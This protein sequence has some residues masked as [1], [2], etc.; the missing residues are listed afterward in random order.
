M[1][2][3]V[4]LSG[5]TTVKFPTRFFRRFR[6]LQWKLT[7]FYTLS[8]VLVLSLL[9]II[10]ALLLLGFVTANATGLLA[11]QVGI[12]GQNIGSNFTGPLV[13]RATLSQALK[14]WRQGS[15]TEFQGF[16]AALD[17]SGHV[18]AAFGDHA[19]A[20]NSDLLR[21]V[22]PGIQQ[23]I[24]EALAVTPATVTNLSTSTYEEKG[25][26]SIVAPMVS[27]Q[28]IRGVLLVI[29]QHVQFHSDNLWEYAPAFLFYGGG[30][31]L[32]F[33]VGAGII[34]L[35]FGVVTAHGL[36]RR[37]KRILASVDGWGRGDFSTL[38]LDTSNDEL[39]QLALRLNHMAE[40]LRDLLHTRQSLAQLQERNRLARELHDSV[41]QQ[42]FALSIWVRNTKGLIGHDEEAARQQIN[43]AEQVIR[44]TQQEL[45]ALIRE[46]R[47]VALSD[48][49]LAQALQEYAH[50]WQKQ[51][52]ISVTFEGS[53]AQL[54]S[55]NIE[56]AFFRIA[57]EALTNVA[58]H[59][60]ASAVTLRLAVGEVV[61]LSIS[62][63]G[64]GFD[65]R[66]ANQQ[67]VGLSSMRERIQALRGHIEIQSEE[68]QG[69]MITLQ[70]E[71]QHEGNTLKSL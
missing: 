48:K 2:V 44:Q 62:D 50:T 7:I 8:T 55:P 17:S 11:T 46:L 63:N 64:R 4:S 43:E 58:R 3:S 25:T 65:V 70:C 24:R 54:A 12:A 36:V 33:F 22:S 1:S 29:A 26:V 68:G 59:S 10:T 30:S 18:L 13:N 60:Q 51:T 53:E 45:T 61:T 49:N 28:K 69:T 16:I 71:Q 19:P 67:G 42:I 38:V 31:L 14:E 35:V 34:G 41:K 21:A 9:E 57:Q 27:E 20:E 66:Q 47:P 5:T 6:R 52:G 39:G 40:Q 56:E 32:I 15:G 23:Q 37:L